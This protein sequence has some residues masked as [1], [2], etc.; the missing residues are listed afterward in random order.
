[1]VVYSD[2]LCHHGILGMKWGVRRYQNPDGTLTVKGRARYAKVASS[3]RL[4]KRDTREA[5]RIYR[6]NMNEHATY[7]AGYE[8]VKNRQLNKFNKFVEK[9]I[10]AREKGDNAKA[11]KYD[12]KATDA[13]VKVQKS[14]S[15]AALSIQAAEWNSKKIQDIDGGKIKAGRDFIVQRDY[16]AYV[17][18]FA[19][20]V[21]RESKII[22]S[23]GTY[24]TEMNLFKPKI[25]R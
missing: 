25:K 10:K 3:E 9:A 15:S 8:N 13:L 17:L 20:Y 19:A 21:T 1:M 5:K 2:E 7:A 12:E 6:K 24:N 14:L 18:P 4:Q 16:N 22:N 23:D 11:Q